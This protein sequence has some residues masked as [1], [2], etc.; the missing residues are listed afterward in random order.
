VRRAVVETLGKIGDSRAIGPLMAASGLGAEAVRNAI[1]RIGGADAERAAIELEHKE[2]EE[3][4]QL[5]QERSGRQ[6][7]IER[8]TAE[9]IAIGKSDGFLSMQPGGKFNEA[10]RNIRAREI[11]E[12]LDEIGG[13]ELMQAVG[14]QVA[15]SFGPGS[16]QGREL[17]AAWSGIGSWH[18]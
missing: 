1:Q 12:R 18:G 11:G 10:M 4:R 7:E 15:R 2:Q 9:L 13:F 3:Q 16:S 17:E 6:E 5:E 14:K 8:L